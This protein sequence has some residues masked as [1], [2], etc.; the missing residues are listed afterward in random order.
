MSGLELRDAIAG[1]LA[2]F[3]RR[4]SPQPLTTAAVAIVL[5]LVN[6][7][8]TVPIFQRTSSMRRHASQMALPGGK[9]HEGE[10]AEQ[11]AIREV[12]EELGLV[13]EPDGVLGKLDDFDTA[14]GFTITPVVLW[15]G[16]GLG[17]LRPDADE[18]GRL[19]LIPI[20]ELR[21]AANAAAAGESTSFSLR[22]H[23]V[24]VFAPTGAIL[25]QFSEV[26]LE[27]RDCR[28]DAFYQPPFTH[29]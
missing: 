25:Y 4:P 15:S 18:V 9:K 20:S 6:G 28:V 12:A 26:A 23:D 8:A 10:T 19:F 3:E 11:C 16:A 29:R 24:E 27:G 13:V 14:S 5:L 7:V 17:G 21:E 22:F 1:R 2:N